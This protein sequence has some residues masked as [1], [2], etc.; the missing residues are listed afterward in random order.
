MAQRLGLVGSHYTACYELAPA[1]VSSEPKR[2]VIAVNRLIDDAELALERSG[3]AGEPLSVVGYSLGSYPATLLANRL[4][5]RVYAVAAADRGDLMIWESAAAAT[6]RRRAAAKGYT[7]EDFSKAMQGYHPVENLDQLATGS[8]FFLGRSDPF[9]P[10]QR[11]SALIEAMRGRSVPRLMLTQGGH[12]QTL[13]YGARWVH[14]EL[15]LPRFSRQ[16]EAA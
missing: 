7:L 8:A 5:A 10:W 13:L 6:I 14:Q 16:A 12:L 15:G 1:L 2:C 11:T 9:I 3:Y 4:G